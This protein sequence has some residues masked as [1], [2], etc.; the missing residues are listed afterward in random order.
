MSRT[1]TPR[2]FACGD[3]LEGKY[4]RVRLKVVLVEQDSEV[5]VAGVRNELIGD[6]RIMITGFLKN[7]RMETVLMMHGIT[8]N[9]INVTELIRFGLIKFDYRK[10][11]GS[12]FRE[13]TCSCTRIRTDRIVVSRKGGTCTSPVG[14][15]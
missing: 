12:W 11:K 2:T 15:S 3:F 7:D 1:I 6:V 5:R 9:S 10:N 4:H 14:R 8:V 13:R